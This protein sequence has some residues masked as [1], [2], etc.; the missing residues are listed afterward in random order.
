M[1]ITDLATRYS[2][3]EAKAYKDHLEQ[4]AFELIGEH[5]LMSQLNTNMNTQ[6]EMALPVGWDNITQRPAK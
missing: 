1:A 6:T 2:R 4:R 5:P 3:E